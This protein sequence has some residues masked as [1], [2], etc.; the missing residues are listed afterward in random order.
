MRAARDAMNS[1]IAEL[2]EGHIRNH[3]LNGKKS[4]AGQRLAAE[5]V[6]EMV[7]SYLK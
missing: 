4:S 5:E 6:V 3:V 2:F 1:L 7:R